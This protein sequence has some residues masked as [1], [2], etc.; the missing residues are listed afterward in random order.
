MLGAHEHL[1]IVGEAADGPEAV[2][3]ARAL[4]P[5]LVL[6]D[7][8]LPTLNGVDAAHQIGRTTPDAKII[9]VTQNRDADVMNAALSNGAR[10]YVFKPRAGRD[11]LPA[12]RAVLRGGTF[13]SA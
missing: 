8:G 9:F 10:G 6:L 2:Q 7:L 13:V 1:Q 12:I 11:L 5:D 4:K 3:K